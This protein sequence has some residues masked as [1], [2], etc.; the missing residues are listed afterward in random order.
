MISSPTVRL[1]KS[2]LKISKIIL[3]C[4]SYGSH[5]WNEWVIDDQEEVTR[6]IKVAYVLQT[7]VYLPYLRARP[8]SSYD[9]G[10][11]TFDTANVDICE[12]TLL[13]WLTV[14]IGVLE[15]AL[16]GHARQSHK[17][18]ETAARGACYHDQGAIMYFSGA[19]S[20]LADRRAPLQL[21][22]AVAPKYDMNLMRMG[23]NPEEAGLVNQRGLCRKVGQTVSRP[24]LLGSIELVST[25]STRSR[26]AWNVF[27]S[28]TLIYCS[29]CPLARTS[30]ASSSCIHG[31]QAIALTMTR[32]SRRL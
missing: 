28:T 27:K 14:C 9:L 2:G 23:V 17:G 25:S 13:H 12:Y 26:R 31:P 7:S 3:G 20:T 24:S 30:V 15:R 16:R 6:H 22:G 18:P 32:P 4:M 8:P 11:Q 29:V 5:G 1:G 10:I 21:F 19:H